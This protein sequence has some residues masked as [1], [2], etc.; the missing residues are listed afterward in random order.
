MTVDGADISDAL[1]VEL[2]SIYADEVNLATPS[3]PPPHTPSS[4]NQENTE[5]GSDLDRL[6]GSLQVR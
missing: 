5:N 1:F 2:D 4:C 3:W 6:L